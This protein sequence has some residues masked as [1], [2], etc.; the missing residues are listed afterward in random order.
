MEAGDEMTIQQRELGPRRTRDDSRT[1][2]VL[3]APHDLWEGTV[4]G[5]APRLARRAR[6]DAERAGC[7]RD[8]IAEPVVPGARALMRCVHA[9]K[10]ICSLPVAGRSLLGVAHPA[11]APEPR[12]CMRARVLTLDP[13]DVRVGDD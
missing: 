11:H 12:D 10:P 8:E 7:F 4:Q 6:F 2:R 9:R 5:S 3:A 1:S 13:R